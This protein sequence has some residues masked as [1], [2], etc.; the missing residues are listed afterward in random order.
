MRGFRGADSDCKTLH[1][2]VSI[3]SQVLLLSSTMVTN[4]SEN[5][6]CVCVCLCVLM[7]RDGALR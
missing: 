2:Y 7:N 5:E 6:K 4:V 1:T 3:V